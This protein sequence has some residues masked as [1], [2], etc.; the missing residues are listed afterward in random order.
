MTSLRSLATSTC[1][2]ILLTA[3]GS[4]A[5]G[6]DAQLPGPGCAP[7]CSG[8]ACGDDGCGGSCGTC[9]GGARCDGAFQCV[10]AQTACV[11]S[12]GGKACGDDGCGGSCGTCAVGTTCS[13]GGTCASASCATGLRCLAEQYTAYA[14]DCARSATTGPWTCAAQ[15]AMG[16][17][18]TRA[19]CETA[20]AGGESGCHEGD[21]K[22]G[23]ECRTCWAACAAA[24]EL[25]CSEE[26]AGSCPAPCACR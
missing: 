17:F 19:L 18:P 9:A 5:P 15:W 8:R 1:L 24:E 7:A 16:A 11:P 4:S 14:Y 2:L 6:G 26:T 10:P 22:V 13:S 3:C 23:A 20:C 25:A 12:C 21:S